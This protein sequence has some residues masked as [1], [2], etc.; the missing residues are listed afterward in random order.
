[1]SLVQQLPQRDEALYHIQLDHV[2]SLLRLLAPSG[3]VR[4][5]CVVDRLLLSIDLGSSDDRA[6]LHLTFALSLDLFSL[7]FI[8]FL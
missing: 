7:L 3:L 4:T 8:F 5:I 2:S 1:M 6:H